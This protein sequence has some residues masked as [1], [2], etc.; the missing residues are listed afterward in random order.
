MPKAGFAGQDAS[1]GPAR[2]A[3]APTRSSQTPQMATMG[4][5]GGRGA[6]GGLRGGGWASG[7]VGLRCRGVELEA[8]RYIVDV[9]GVDL[10]IA[11]ICI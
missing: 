2:L 8:A 9:F 4:P 10:D 6:H 7:K 5:G 1:V 3:R 11:L